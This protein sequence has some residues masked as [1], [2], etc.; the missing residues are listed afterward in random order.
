MTTEAQTRIHARAYVDKM[1]AE[2]VKQ[3][4]GRDAALSAV[5]EGLVEKT[6]RKIEEEIALKGVRLNRETFGGFKRPWKK[7]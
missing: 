4:Q 2:H 5:K 3:K 1:N 7:S 6:V